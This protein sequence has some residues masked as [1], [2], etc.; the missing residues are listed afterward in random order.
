MNELKN[1]EI[2]I[3]LEK[4]NSIIDGH[5]ELS[6]GLHSDKYF[7]CAKLLQYPEFAEIAAL[8][9][10]KQFTS[11]IDVVVG[12][13]LGGIIIAYEVARVLNARSIFTERKDGIM[14]IRRGFEIQENENVIIVEDVI[15]TAKSIIETEKVLKN[16]NCNIIGYGCIIDRS[17]ERTG[18]N[19]H[20]LVKVIANTYNP[21]ECPLCKQGIPK[22]KP[23]S[24]VKT[25]LMT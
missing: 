17:N 21:K 24:R 20:S 1:A 16:F 3:L 15:T 10:A 4:T 23:G 5:F 18:L 9:L 13:A 14:S 22:E 19:I 6:S 11:R 8:T 12:P 7:Q 25:L 2:K